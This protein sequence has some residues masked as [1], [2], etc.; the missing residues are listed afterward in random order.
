[1][2]PYKYFSTQK[3][4]VSE[5]F[6]CTYARRDRTVLKRTSHAWNIPCIIRVARVYRVKAC[7]ACPWPNSFTVTSALT[8]ILFRHGQRFSSLTLYIRPLQGV[9]TCAA[10]RW[11][12]GNDLA[13]YMGVGQHVF[14]CTVG[15][16]C[17]GIASRIY[18]KTTKRKFQ[19]N[20]NAYI[21][22]YSFITWLHVSTRC[23]SS[24]GQRT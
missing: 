11:C 6:L 4:K 22:V 7:P 8:Y 15:R 10:H 21:L 2:L 24:S 3:C 5:E 17:V 23:E 16:S 9:I 20:A 19:S 18:V 14:E 1:M 13:V 12:H